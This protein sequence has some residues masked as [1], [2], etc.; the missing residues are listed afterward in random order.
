MAHARILFFIFSVLLQFLRFHRSFCIHTWRL[1]RFI[2]IAQC[3]S[4]LILIIIELFNKYSNIAIQYVKTPLFVMSSMWDLYQLKQMTP[5]KRRKS[6]N[7][8]LPPT[9]KKEVTYLESFANNS[10]R[11]VSRVSILHWSSILHFMYFTFVVTV[12]DSSF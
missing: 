10:Y 2:S 1:W 4:C 7:I 5:T 12:S 8:H 9:L 6:D 11:S 3:V